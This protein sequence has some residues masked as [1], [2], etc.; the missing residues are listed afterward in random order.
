MRLPKLASVIHAFV[1]GIWLSKNNATKTKRYDSSKPNKA[2]N[3]FEGIPSTIVKFKSVSTSYGGTM[4]LDEEN[5][6][7][8]FGKFIRLR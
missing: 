5:N 3:N 2:P 4:L 8:E 6:L 7:Y 1:V